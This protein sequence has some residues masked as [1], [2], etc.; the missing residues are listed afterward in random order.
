VIRTLIDATG[1]RKG[2]GS[3]VPFRPSPLLN[4]VD[5]PMLV[6]QLEYLRQ[7][8]V[9][10]CDLLIDHHPKM[11]EEALEDG[12]RWD[13]QLHYYRAHNPLRPFA[14]F[15][16]TAQQMGSEQLLLVNG[17]TLPAFLFKQLLE[18]GA[19]E[20]TLLYYADGVWTGW[21]LIPAELLSQVDRQTGLKA[22]GRLTVER[23]LSVES[24]AEVHQSN[25]KLLSERPASVNFPSTAKMIAPGIWISRAASLHPDVSLNAPVFI[26]ENCRIEKECR[27]GPH[28]IIENNCLID[29]GSVIEQSLVCQESY[30]GEKLQLM[31]SI[32]HQEHLI[33][34]TLK[35][36]VLIKDRFILSALTF[37]SPKKWIISLRKRLGAD[38]RSIKQFFK[39]L[40]TKFREYARV[41]KKR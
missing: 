4:I 16:A 33:N 8:G 10:R 40:F 34:L 2:L 24:Y 28:A 12:S 23:F 20:P 3:L 11:I 17:N 32:V 6:H 19:K 35:T 22:A 14:S 18:A 21:G 7:Q 13:I 37:P 9:T 1:I 41:A 26:G 27:I 39:Q 36:N 5:K 31:N 30:V 25:Q 29:N 15:L 38:L